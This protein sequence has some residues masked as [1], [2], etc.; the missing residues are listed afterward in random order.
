MSSKDP[1]CHL[2]AAAVAA[3]INFPLW[4]ASAIAQSGFKVE[5]ATAWERYYTA[6]LKPPFRGTIATVGGMT[7]AR[8]AI[9]FGSDYG[10]LI[11]NGYLFTLNQTDR[12][13]KCSQGAWVFW[14]LGFHVSAIGMQCICSDSKYAL[15][16]VHDYYTGVISSGINSAI[17]LETESC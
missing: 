15:G 12:R 2:F 14:N 11:D 1:D 8:A 10:V 3:V 6:A 16:S 9:F 4:R 7:W 5:G 13:E 17:T